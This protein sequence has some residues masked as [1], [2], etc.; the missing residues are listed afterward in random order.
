MDEWIIQ[1]PVPE[2]EISASN[3]YV[4]IGGAGRIAFES[5][6]KSSS[7]SNLGRVLPILVTQILELDLAEIQGEDLRLTFTDFADLPENQITAF[8]DLLE[9]SPFSIKIRMSSFLGAPNSAFS[10]EF[11]LN[12]NEVKPEIKG[13]FCKSGDKIYL[14]DSQSFKLLS[15]VYKFNNLSPAHKQS[16]DAF[17][18][19]G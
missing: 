2:I 18:L 13:C 6:W 1:Q 16:P 12:G 4:W 5:D 10:L 7:Y 8:A 9:R 15:E 19:F 17:R 3:E 11:Y 14:F